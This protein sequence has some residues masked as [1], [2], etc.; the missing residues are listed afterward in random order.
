MRMCNIHSCTLIFYHLKCFLY[1]PYKLNLYRIL[2][3]R[4]SEANE[5]SVEM[6]ENLLV[7]SAENSYIVVYRTPREYRRI[8]RAV[9]LMIDI[10]VSFDDMLD[11]QFMKSKVFIPFLLFQMLADSEVGIRFS[12]SV[13]I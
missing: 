13:Q 12:C 6:V 9:G 3:K 11:K 10:R 8:A 4:L 7:P 2:R 1:R 5:I